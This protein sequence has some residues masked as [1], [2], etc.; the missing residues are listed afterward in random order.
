MKTFNQYIIAGLAL[1]CSSTVSAQ[2]LNSAYFTKDFQFRHEMNPAFENERNYVAIPILGN[3]NV[4]MHGNFGVEDVIFSNPMPNG[5]G[6]TTFLNPYISPAEALSGFHSGDNKIFTDINIG[7]LSGG[8]KSWGGYNTVELNLRANA[9]VILPYELFEFAKQTGNR[10][11]N[12]GDI[13][14]QAQSFMELAFGHSRQ[15]TEKLRL[16]AKVKFLFGIGR[17]HIKMTDMRADLTEGNRWVISGNA[18]A[19]VSMKGFEATN[20][21]KNFKVKNGQYEYI[22]DVKVKNPGIGGFGLALDLG[23]IYKIDQD[24]TVSASLTDLGFIC[25]DSD[26]KLSNESK[27]FVFDGFHDIAVKKD[28]DPDHSIGHQA[29]SYSDQLAEFA[30]LK[31]QGNKGS[32]TTGIGAT[33][34]LAGEY[35]LPVYRPI[36]FGLLSTTRI[37]GKYSWTEG[38][39]SANYEPLPWLNGGVSFAVNNFTTSM[40]WVL[41]IHPKYYNFFIGMDHIFCKTNKNGIPLGSNASVSL[42]MSVTW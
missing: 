24:W 28:R 19:D 5:K 8:F 13:N 20:K 4:A 11:Y 39:L 12:I 32:R 2:N 7:L 21:Q 10:V 34:R 26:E 1:V 23:G 3:A 31:N 14:A 18:D 22:D 41:N 25:W 17:A 15:I 29:D 27:E 42:G 35:N 37:N 6:Y 40:G 16:G 33:M 36:T 38:R 30:H 9:G